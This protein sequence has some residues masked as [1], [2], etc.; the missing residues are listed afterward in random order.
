MLTETRAG[1]PIIANP[2]CETCHGFRSGCY[3]RGGMDIC[4]PFAGIP[5]DLGPPPE[6]RVEL[7][8][9]H[10]RG[11]TWLMLTVAPEALGG[12]RRL[13]PGGVRTE[14]YGRERQDVLDD[15]ERHVPLVRAYLAHIV[16]SRPIIFLRDP[17]NEVWLA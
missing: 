12:H 13:H 8:S 4:P 6:Y 7:H 16:G 1:T 2:D 3:L 5:V 9:G 17:R 10:G 15:L 11:G 14:V